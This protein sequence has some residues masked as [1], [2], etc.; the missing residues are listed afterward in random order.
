MAGY[1][2]SP[3]ETKKNR[4]LVETEGR[5]NPKPLNIIKLIMISINA[6]F[7]PTFFIIS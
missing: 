3:I 6:N 7:A 1:F 4:P 5:Q 2:F